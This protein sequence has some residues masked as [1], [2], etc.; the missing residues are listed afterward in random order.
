[1]GTTTSTGPTREKAI[2]FRRE[3]ISAELRTIEGA[4]DNEIASAEEQR[5]GA[6]ERLANARRE[7]AALEAL[8]TDAT[9]RQ[10]L[11]ALDLLT[12]PYWQRALAEIESA[13]AS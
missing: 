6:R 8:P 3:W 2:A 7:L 4:R 10:I 13:V 12:D 5:G 11:D 9:P 1:M